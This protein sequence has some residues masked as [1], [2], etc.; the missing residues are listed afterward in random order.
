MAHSTPAEE[1]LEFALEIVRG[2]VEACPD[3]VFVKDAAGRY[4]LANEAASR[5]LGRDVADILGRHDTELLPAGAAAPK[6][7][8]DRRVMDEGRPITRQARYPA[9]GTSRTVREARSPLRDREGQVSGVLVIASDVADGQGPNTEACRLLFD[10]IPEPMCVFDV[11]THRYLEVNQATVDQYGYSRDELL[12]MTVPDIHPPDERDAVLQVLAGMKGDGMR[13]ATPLRHQ[14]KDGS[15]LDV[16]VSSR[17][18]EFLGRRA[19]LGVGRDI[20]S[21]R[22]AEAALRTSEQTFRAVFEGA[23]DAMVIVDDDGRFVDAN[24]AA[25]R[26]F[27]TP[28]GELMGQSRD[29]FLLPAGAD[30]AGLDHLRRPDGTVRLV[31]AAQARDILPG[32]HLAVLRDVTERVQAESE[33]RRQNERFE[34]VFDNIPVMIGIID[35]T[36]RIVT[37][38]REAERVLGY[39]REELSDRDVLAEVHPDPEAY[40]TAVDTIARSPKGWTEVE[41]RVRDGHTVYAA[42]ASHRL[43]DGTTVSIGQDITE[44]KQAEKALRESEAGYRLLAETVTDMISRHDARGRVRFISPSCQAILGRRPGEML[45]HN[46]IEYINPEDLPAATAA[47]RSVL[48]GEGPARVEYRMRHHDGHDVWVETNLRLVDG[49]RSDVIC[50]TRDVSARKRAEQARHDSERFA[51]SVLDALSARIAVVD[52][53]GKILMV[54]RSWRQFAEVN[55]LGDVTGGNLVYTAVCAAS[56]APERCQVCSPV[57]QALHE[58]LGGRVGVF[59]LEYKCHAPERDRWF[60]CLVTTFETADG[61]RAVIAHEEVTRQKLAEQS[62]RV[63][64]ERLQS[65]RAIDQAI[66]ASRST[67]EIA[68]SVLGHLE[69]FV[70]C[71]RSGIALVDPVTLDVKTVAETGRMARDPLPAWPLSAL[72]PQAEETLR[73]GQPVIIADLAADAA[74]DQPFRRLRDAGVRRVSVHPFLCS[75]QLM[76][77]LYLGSDRPEAF[78]EEQLALVSE[79]ADQFTVAIRHVQLFEEVHAGRERLRALSVR[80]IRAQEDERR[81]IARELHDEVG[82]A[83]TAAKIALQTA[84]RSVDPATA[85]D[86]IGDALGLID[87]TLGQVRSLSLDL[88]PSLLDDLGL[89]PAL[90][91]HV[92][93][94]KRRTGLGA[95]LEADPALPRVDPDI[96]TACYR[97]AQEALTNVVRHSGATE[98]TVSL[99]RSEGA[100][101]LQV[102]DNGK[103]FDTEPAIARATAGASLG[104][105]GM[106]ERVSL[107]GGRFQLVSAPGRGTSV[108]ATF[109]EC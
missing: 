5:L 107:A 99:T 28:H 34:A 7:E 27:G 69:R 68:E 94:L 88:R 90:R 89:V 74:L 83:L 55:G 77:L 31:E 2:L 75:G 65:L 1:T 82:Q 80:L 21:Q 60:V 6:V 95:R 35:S 104:L 51:R 4:V 9:L 98:V 18:I 71:R 16:E 102:V 73:A 15:V 11:E 42:W 39:S 81:H 52:R 61:R 46:M 36:P 24:P 63:Y 17:P 3:A 109:L 13:H 38:N 14:R 70:A 96:E 72:G 93:A 78:T 25:T 44:R 54:N 37:H 59:E 62:L 29:A 103:G 86:R 87:R 10:A 108:R 50:S 30:A 97:V 41:M 49:S 12:A 64:T 105:L 40:R 56:G 26:L 92:S 33:L 45:G 85:V 48:A 84:A 67:D 8:A 106:H 101:V 58:V 57:Q 53:E 32:R 79:V 47:V 66:L 20:T 22:R 23:L 43:S 91:S 100:L 76:G 19:R